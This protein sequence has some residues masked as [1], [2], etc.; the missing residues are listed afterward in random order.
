MDLTLRT[1]AWG[2][3]E[4]HSNLNIPEPEMPHEKVW[5]I[6]FSSFPLAVV[7]WSFSGVLFV[8]RSASL[9][10]LHSQASSQLPFIG[11]HTCTSQ[12]QP[13]H[14]YE[15]GRARSWVNTYSVI[16]HPLTHTHPLT[17]T[18]TDQPTLGTPF[19]ISIKT[20]TCRL[21]KAP[22]RPEWTGSSAVRNQEPG[23]TSST[24][25]HWRESRWEEET[26]E[27]CQHHQNSCVPASLLL[28]SRFWI[29]ILIY[30]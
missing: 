1:H 27:V 7:V 12:H 19:F 23:Q 30:L 8:S 17:R 2:D 20:L 15:T 6:S 29:F 22:G 3:A 28:T 26:Q 11:L 21:R 10:P 13:V 9:L 5:A 24:G 18:H 4:N 14:T 16:S 25:R